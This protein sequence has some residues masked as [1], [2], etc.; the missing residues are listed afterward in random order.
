M[1]IRNFGEKPCLILILIQGRSKI[2]TEEIENKI[3]ELLG[4]L[5]EAVYEKDKE[6]CE[7]IG[8]KIEAQI[9]KMDALEGGN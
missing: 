4:L 8:K 3:N 5:T 7:E 1:P 2:M 9:K 6:K